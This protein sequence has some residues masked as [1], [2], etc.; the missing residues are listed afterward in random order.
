MSD[1]NKGNYMRNS[2]WEKFTEQ[3]IRYQDA[4]LENLHPQLNQAR[5]GYERMKKKNDY[6]GIKIHG[7]PGIGKTHFL[8][9][10]IRDLMENFNKTDFDLFYVSE[11]DLFSQLKNMMDWQDGNE[12]KAELFRRIENVPFLFYDDLGAAT[13]SISGDWGKQQLMEIFN[14]RYNNKKTTFITTNIKDEECVNLIGDRLSSRF[15]DL[16]TVIIY[17][18]DLREDWKKQE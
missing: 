5:F 6:R 1:G 7:P 13:K 15:K 9:A 18:E 14:S 8:M 2:L 16:H 17:G 12:E 4:T 11:E 10:V 3:Y